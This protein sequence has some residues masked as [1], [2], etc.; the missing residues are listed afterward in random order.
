[1]VAQ[2]TL[3]IL[4]LDRNQAWEHLIIGGYMNKYIDRQALISELLRQSRD[5]SFLPNVSWQ[6]AFKNLAISLS[7][8]WLAPDQPIIPE[9]SKNCLVMDKFNR[10]WQ[11]QNETQTWHTSNGKSE[12]GGSWENVIVHRPLRFYYI[13]QE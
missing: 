11:W 1:M 10:I 7:E 6:D 2:D 5:F 9:P 13:T 8:N 12:L 4:D 3:D